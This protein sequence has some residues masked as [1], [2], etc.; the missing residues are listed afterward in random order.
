MQHGED[1]VSARPFPSDHYIVRTEQMND[2]R[3]GAASP[4]GRKGRMSSVDLLIGG[5]RGARTGVSVTADVGQPS[6]PACG[7]LKGQWISRYF[8]PLKHAA[9]FFIS[10]SVEGS[11]SHH[12]NL[13]ITSESA[14]QS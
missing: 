10:E 3:V 6:F 5:A 11:F 7:I 8:L 1:L 4:G 12:H 14:E 9:R 2:G 13:P